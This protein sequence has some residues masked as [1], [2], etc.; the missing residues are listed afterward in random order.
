MTRMT[1]Q[2]KTAI[3][4]AEKKE[5]SGRRLN[6]RFKINNMKFKKK[7]RKKRAQDKSMFDLENDTL[8]DKEVKKTSQKPCCFLC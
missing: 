6:K 5:Q 8:E 4:T 1:F 7:N 2:R 3:S